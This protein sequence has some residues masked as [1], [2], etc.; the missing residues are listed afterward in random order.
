MSPGLVKE[1][2]KY[3]YYHILIHITIMRQ[4]VE[5][6]TINLHVFKYLR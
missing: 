4:Y 6:N 1:H 5:I 2:L 3:K